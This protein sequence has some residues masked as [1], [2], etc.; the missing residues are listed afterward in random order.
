MKKEIP[1]K[2]KKVVAKAGKKSRFKPKA[3]GPSK[4]PRG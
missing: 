1:P 4:T 3:P 2:V